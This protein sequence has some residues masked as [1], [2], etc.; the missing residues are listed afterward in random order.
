MIIGF[1]FFGKG[2]NGNAW[3]TAIPTSQ[4]DNLYINEGIYDEMYMSLDTTIPKDN[5]KDDWSL[6]TIIN[7]EFQNDLE[8][9]TID[10]NGHVVSRLQLYRREFSSNADW[11][12]IGDTSYEHKFNVYSFIDNTA[13][14]GRS[15]E[16]A[17]APMSN[18]I[19][20]ELNVSDRH[21]IEYSGI[22]ISDSENNFRIEFDFE[23]GDVTHNR[24][25][26]EI[27]PLNGKYPVVVVG[28][29]DYRTSQINFLP[30]SQKQISKGGTKVN[31]RDE[32]NVRSRITSFLNNGK[33][34]IL[35]NDNGDIMI[36]ATHGTTTSTKDI[37]LPD[38]QSVQFD[39]TE[40]GDIKNGYLANAGL[41]VDAVKATYT[42]NEFGD[43]VWDI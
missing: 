13:E 42:Y 24:N 10:A 30:L 19:M 9:G 28:N 31:G 26:S 4:L 37:S 2:L 1:D 38:I 15:Y 21:Q 6:K 35:R 18:E 27:L 17:I 34:K 29:Q 41:V 12:L 25:V 39:Y 23:Q 32:M 33:S 40:I 5:K 8:A 7:P 22:F 43:V 20:G 14:N 36:I 3:D 11:I 16:Y